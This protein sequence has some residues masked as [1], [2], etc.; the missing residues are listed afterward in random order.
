MT[1]LKQEHSIITSYIQNIYGRYVNHVDE[2][3]D[4]IGIKISC[5]K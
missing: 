2:Y 1:S 3:Q 5:Q 4:T